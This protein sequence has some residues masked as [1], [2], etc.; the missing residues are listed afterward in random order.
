V[1]AFQSNGCRSAVA[2]FAVQVVDLPP[3]VALQSFPENVCQGSPFELRFPSFANATYQWQTPS[4][5]FSQNESVLRFA[6][7]SP[8]EAGIYRVRA[9]T[10]GC[11][12]EVAQLNLN[13]LP[14]PVITFIN[15]PATACAREIVTLQAAATGPVQNWLWLGPEGFQAVTPSVNLVAETYLSGTYT[16]IATANNG[17]ADTARANIAVNSAKGNFSARLLSN[18]ELCS[19]ESLRFSATVT[20]GEGN[21]RYQWQGPNNF[22]STVASPILNF[23]GVEN[24]GIYSVEARN[25]QNC[26]IGGAVFS[27]NV[28]AVPPTPTII[29]APFA[30]EASEIKMRVAS[31]DPGSVYY[32]EGPNQWRASGLEA[33]IPTE[34]TPWGTYSLRASNSAGCASPEA[35]ITLSPNAS[36]PSPRLRVLSS[37]TL[38]EGERLEL[39]GFS[40]LPQV[41]YQWRGPG[42]TNLALNPNLIIENAKPGASGVYSLQ[43]FS[44][45]C[46]SPLV[47]S[48]R[49]EVKPAPAPPTVQG[50][51][52]VCEGDLL[53]LAVA[54]P[55]DTYTY[56]WETPSGA[57]SEGRQVSFIAAP[58]TTGL[59]RTFAQAPNNCR[60]EAASFSVTLV[61]TPL[62]IEITAARTQ[63]CQGESLLLEATSIGGAS[64][65]WLTPKGSVVEDNYVF[66]PSVD[67]TDGGLYRVRVA[68]LG[69]QS[70]QSIAI[71]VNA[72]PQPPIVGYNGLPCPEKS[73]Q[74]F[75]QGRPEQ[76]YFWQSENW[77]SVESSPFV[78]LKPAGNT[79]QVVAIEKGCSSSFSSFTIPIQPAGLQVT[80][81][82]GAFCALDSIRLHFS[83]TGLGPWY[84][85]IDIN[86]AAQ[87]LFLPQAN[88]T[89]SLP[90]TTPTPVVIVQSVEDS[91]ACQYALNQ[92]VNIARQNPPL[93]EWVARNCGELAA[94]RVGNIPAGAQWEISYIE[95]G[96]AKTMSGFGEGIYPVMTFGVGTLLQLQ[97]IRAQT[98]ERVCLQPLQGNFIIGQTPVA[99][100]LNVEQEICIGQ[101][102]AVRLRLEG[103][104]P[105]LIRMTNGNTI[106]TRTL[107]NASIEG[108]WETTFEFTPTFGVSGYR[109]TEVIDGTGCRPTLKGEMHVR[110]RQP[111]AAFLNRN[112]TACAGAPFFIPLEIKGKGPWLLHYLVNNERLSLTIPAGVYPE[113]IYSW[114]YIA[115]ENQELELISVQD[116]DN[117]PGQITQANSKLSIAVLPGPAI[118][119]Q[120]VGA[121]VLCPKANLTLR[122][123]PVAGATSYIWQGPGGFSAS[124]ESV[125]RTILSAA[126]AGVYSV[127]IVAPGCTSRTA[128]RTVSLLPLPT[129][130]VFP[131]N[132]EICPGESAQVEVR[133]LE[134][135]LPWR[136]TYRLGEGTVQ[137]SDVLNQRSVTLNLVPGQSGLFRVLEVVELAGCAAQPGRI[138]E[139]FIQVGGA[140]CCP[141]PTVRSIEPMARIEKALLRWNPALNAACYAVE[142]WNGAERLSATL[143]PAGN[144]S[145]FLPLPPA[146]INY[147]VRLQT[148]CSLCS[149]SQGNASNFS[150]FVNYGRPQNRNAQVSSVPLRAYPNPTTG[151]LKVELPE[152]AHS[153]YRLHNLQGE[154]L[155]SGVWE[156]NEGAELN[157]TDFA[158]GFY[159][160]EVTQGDW[161]R[162][163]KILKQ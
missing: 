37:T 126:E 67:A 119:P 5:S 77:S 35:R 152:V 69:C 15:A 156:E 109:L 17:C 80:S 158:Q 153:R 65:Q 120:I 116:L 92:R 53:V 149:F 87:R 19:G 60:S 54:N 155:L 159:L 160:L 151:Y 56:F 23:V 14:A 142:V 150:V 85:N 111:Q 93:V 113:N 123:L 6:N 27:I 104:G 36:L 129:A 71:T 61:A 114:N 98:A 45:L 91:R 66:I 26:I 79:F 39:E 90:I 161:R 12:T 50:R 99:E 18:P 130:A 58:L 132:Q 135:Q 105:W 146:G 47:M 103:K 121:S 63:V 2:A 44:G 11:T 81:S 136:F 118:E 112:V 107:G 43:I 97:N 21:I 74:L 84:A 55:I 137:S 145:L 72:R 52:L 86:G 75:A 24:S 29:V 34:T 110:F 57:L 125:S 46:A 78:T 124:G 13:I 59:Y 139:S 49:I 122:V 163:I 157:L 100:I 140:R 40:N 101:P 76:T 42:N 64:L 9:F 128:T 3:I 106:E 95:N 141:A 144:D 41:R 28:K 83:A 117:C 22:T 96:N 32:W 115:L 1:Q 148:N 33:S 162:Q 7:A 38:C 30:C 94:L 31:P 89:L 127:T 88:Y 108:P 131:A 62:P 82:T 70:E 133:L 154:L 10:A 25:E 48:E 134:G 51:G 143:V 8:A 102:V 4:G 16:V 20:N 138:A 73:I 147:A 68:A